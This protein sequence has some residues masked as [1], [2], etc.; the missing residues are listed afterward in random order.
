MRISVFGR[1]RSLWILLFP[2]AKKRHAKAQ[3]REASAVGVGLP[4]GAG[5]VAGVGVGVNAGKSI[6]RL[7][8]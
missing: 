4:A 6:L 7:T 3:G 8:V 2:D 5:L 1:I